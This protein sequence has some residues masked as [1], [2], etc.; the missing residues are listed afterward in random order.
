[1]MNSPFVYSDEGGDWVHLAIG[2]TVGAAFNVIAHWDD[3]KERGFG[4]FLEA[5]AVG[6]GAGLLTAATGNLAVGA[7]LMQG[8]VIGAVSGISGDILL[9]TGNGVFFDDQYDAKQ[10]LI[11]GGLGAAGGVLTAYITRPKPQFSAGGGTMV[12]LILKIV[13]IEM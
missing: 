12:I 10:A 11:P 3:V 13:R 2:A 5:A 7:T 1:M 8:A 4:A 9:Q 6:A